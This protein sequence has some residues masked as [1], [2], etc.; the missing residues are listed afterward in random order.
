[1]FR[2]S[3]VLLFSFCRRRNCESSCLRGCGI[4]RAFGG[5]RAGRPIVRS[6]RRNAGG[7]DLVGTIVNLVSDK[8]KDL[9][10]LGFQQVRESAKGSKAT[11]QF[12]ALLPKLSADAQ[13]GLLDA[14]ADRGDK[15]ARPAVLESA[16]Q[17][18]QSGSRRRAAC[19]RLARRSG[20]R[21]A[22][23][24]IA[25][26]VAGAGK[27][28]GLVEPCLTCRVRPLIRRS[29]MRRKERPRILAPS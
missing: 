9:R 7:D 26:G 8:D 24:A 6:R 23:R 18:R 21:S 10:A 12:A 22:S 2:L 25:G 29:P 16:R 28:D 19:S 11:L 15:A 4:F 14:L 20:R 27:I 13:P 17:P 5:C 3:D 1:M